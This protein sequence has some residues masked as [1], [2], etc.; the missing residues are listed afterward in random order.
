MAE[1]FKVPGSSYE[2]IVKIIKA[3]ASGKSGQG[4]NLEDVA[5][6]SGMDKTVVSRNNGFLVSTELISEG[7]KKIPSDYCMNLGRAYTLNMVDE[8]K[9]IWAKVIDANEFLMKMLTAIKVRNGMEKTNF[10]SHILYSAGLTTKGAKTGANTII[11]IFKVANLV[12]EVDGQITAC[13]G[14]TDSEEISE[15]GGDVPPTIAT[16]KNVSE[17]NEV[18]S[19]Q[20]GSLSPYINLNI[21]IE[22]K[23][24]EL[25]E[26]PEKIKLLLDSIRE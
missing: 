22:V 17:K 5:Q 10:L 11:E 19:I 26:L 4:M 18:I 1:N 21:N 7:N 13:I 2:E 14:G 9:K 6:S 12:E 16:Q 3:Y 25:D 15:V 8:V 23:G 24:S 20:K